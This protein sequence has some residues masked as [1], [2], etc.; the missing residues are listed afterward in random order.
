MRLPE[1]IR[2]LRP[3]KNGASPADGDPPGSTLEATDFLSTWALR[4]TIH[5]RERGGRFYCLRRTPAHVKSLD[6]VVVP[7]ARFGRNSYRNR[8]SCCIECNTR[9]GDRPAPDFLRTLYRQG[10]LTPA[11]LD[12]RLRALRALAAGK[13]SHSGGD[14]APFRLARRLRQSR[15]LI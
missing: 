3:G 14:T 12:G 4:K 2:A 1:Q 9:K 6:H 5:D 7:R 8:V 10:R 11:E 13:L 15:L